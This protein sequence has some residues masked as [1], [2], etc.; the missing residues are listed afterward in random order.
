MYVVDLPLIR[1]R[2]FVG[3][4]E[5]CTNSAERRKSYWLPSVKTGVVRLLASF[6]I[7]STV[8]CDAGLT[9]VPSGCASR[10]EIK[11]NPRPAYGRN[12]P[13]CFGNANS[14]TLYRRESLMS[15]IRAD[16]TLVGS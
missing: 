7:W 13:Y 8:S 1:K 5:A 14:C 15:T 6:T 12:E 2:F 11:A 3:I 16:P 4:A 10:I 9:N